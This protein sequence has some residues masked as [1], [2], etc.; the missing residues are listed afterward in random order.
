MVRSQ[1]V[2][3]NHHL[4]ISTIAADP[5]RSIYRIRKDGFCGVERVGHGAKVIAKAMELM[6]DDLTFNLRA[7]CGSVRFGLITLT[8]KYLDGFSLDDCISVEFC[9]G[10]EILP[11]WK[12]KMPSEALHKQVRVVHRVQRRC[13]ARHGCHRASLYTSTSAKV[14]RSSGD[15]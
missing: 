10:T 1:A 13:S 5:E 2:L 6:E 15:I 3:R 8:G 14:C 7:D 12:E 4:G 9:Q 11:W